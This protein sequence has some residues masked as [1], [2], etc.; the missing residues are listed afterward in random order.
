MK[1]IIGLILI[2]I[3]FAIALTVNFFIPCTQPPDVASLHNILSFSALIIF[4]SGI[5]IIIPYHIIP[6]AIFDNEEQTPNITPKNLILKMRYRAILF[7]NISVI[8]FFFTLF[9]I[10][11]GSYFLVSPTKETS[12]P[13][14]ITTKT[15]ISFLLIF[16]AAMLFRVFKYLLRV[17]A[18]Y[19]A[20]ADA[21][22]FFNMKPGSELEKLMEL[23][24]PDKYDISDLQQ[25]TLSEIITVLKG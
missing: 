16:L 4:I 24:T 12:I 8:I 22:E 14:S 3:S 2:G 7:N 1:R 25:P 23:F 6:R 19:N 10:I 5:L 11:I 17:A 20:K 21:I 13:V 15:S 9:V 18:F